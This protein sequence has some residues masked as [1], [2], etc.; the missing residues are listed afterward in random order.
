MNKVVKEMFNVIAV[1]MMKKNLSF[2]ILVFLGCFRVCKSEVA[3][4]LTF[5]N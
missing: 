1:S 3:L 4:V 5:Y 2:S